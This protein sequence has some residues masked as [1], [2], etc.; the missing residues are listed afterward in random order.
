VSSRTVDGLTTAQSNP[1]FFTKLV[2]DQRLREGMAFIGRYSIAM[3]FARNADVKIE[4]L[5]ADKRA[6][7][8]RHGRVVCQDITCSIGDVQDLSASGMRV[9]TRYKLPEEGNVFVIT[10]LTPDGPLA[11]LSRVRWI[12]RVGLFAREAGLE[13][14]DL[15]PK[16]K[17]VLQAM[18]G[19]AAYNESGWRAA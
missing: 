18:A 11:I 4:Q 10:L 8:R 1:A 5:G 3:R 16:S 6:E 7:Q 9:R 15:G 2:V 14:F 13:F 17:Q 12:K 19:R